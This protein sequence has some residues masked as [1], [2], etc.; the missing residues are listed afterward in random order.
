MAFC[1]GVEWIWLVTVKP[2]LSLTLEMATLPLQVIFCNFI[3]WLWRSDMANYHIILGVVIIVLKFLWSP[4]TQV[5]LAS[6]TE[7]IYK[8]GSKFLSLFQGLSKKVGVSSSILQGLWISYSTEGLSMALASLRNLYTPNIKVLEE[9]RESSGHQNLHK[10]LQWWAVTMQSI[11]WSRV[12]F[13][14]QA[15]Q[16]AGCLSWAEERHLVS[17]DCLSTLLL[18]QRISFSLQ[19]A[20]S[21]FVPVQNGIFCSQ[22]CGMQ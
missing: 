3:N 18:W 9:E 6:V 14:G 10:K 2:C 21:E 4:E 13:P 1:E 11:H 12:Q 15:E 5:D 22:R 19:W 16:L 8:C 17:W 20:N 7:Q